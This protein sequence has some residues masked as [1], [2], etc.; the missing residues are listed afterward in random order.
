VATPQQQLMS[1]WV[2]GYWF[3][4]LC[5]TLHKI[6]Y[7]RDTF[8][9]HTEETE[10]NTTKAIHIQ[11]KNGISYSRKKHTKSKPKTKAVVDCKNCS[12]FGA[13]HIGKS[14]LCEYV[15]AAYYT[16]C[17]IFQPLWNEMGWSSWFQ[18]SLY[19]ISATYLVFIQSAYFFKCCIK[20]TCLI[21]VHNCNIQYWTVLSSYPPD[22]YQMLSTIKEG[23]VKQTENKV[24]DYN[25]TWRSSSIQYATHY[26]TA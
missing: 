26:N 17:C 25:I 12:C 10:T 9:S 19:H 23:K 6:G 24:V 11:T 4:V 18:A 13:Y 22:N 21:T 1:Y 16:Y 15:I 14:V 7:F 3:K 2:A 8:L 20:M 5:P